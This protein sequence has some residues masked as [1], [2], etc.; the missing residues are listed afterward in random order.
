MAKG[1]TG[2]SNIASQRIVLQ[3]AEAVHSMYPDIKHQ[4][5]ARLQVLLKPSNR[6]LFDSPATPDTAII[7]LCNFG[8]SRRISSNK[9]FGHTTVAPWAGSTRAGRLQAGPGHEIG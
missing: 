5:V 8:I 9:D 1:S 4:Q 7:E 6:L 3:V 2:L